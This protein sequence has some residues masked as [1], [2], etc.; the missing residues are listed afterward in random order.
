VWTFNLLYTKKNNTTK[1][2]QNKNRQSISLSMQ[3]T[4]DKRQGRWE[5][6]GTTGG[7]QG[8]GTKTHTQEIPRRIVPAGGALS[9]NNIIHA[10]RGEGARPG[11]GGKK[12]LMV[13]RRARGVFSM[14]CG[15]AHWGSISVRHGGVS[16]L[17]FDTAGG[18]AR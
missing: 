11:D 10:K 15:G 6:A 9:E 1:M 13:V 7:T 3:S 18:G 14:P 12:Q 17:V 5:R 2:G 8:A 4:S 16:A